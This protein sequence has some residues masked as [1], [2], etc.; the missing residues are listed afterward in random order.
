MKRILLIGEHPYLLNTRAAILRRLG[1]VEVRLPADFDRNPD[2]ECFDLLI[3]C[4]SL[5][6]HT[7]QAASLAARKRWPGI[8]V[9]QLVRYSRELP[10]SS[11]ADDI[12][13]ATEPSDVIRC[14]ERLL[15]D[16]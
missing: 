2:G 3:L 8:R 1:S 13:I 7:V 6:G 9:L 14:A 16:K 5:D 4:H 15:L 10:Q 11:A 12:A